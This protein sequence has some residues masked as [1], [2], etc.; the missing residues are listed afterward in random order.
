M[1]LGTRFR[2]VSLRSRLGLA[3]LAILATTVLA[4]SLLLITAWNASAVL[5]EGRQAQDR[6]RIYTQIQDAAR[7]YQAASYQAV[8]DTSPQS[9]R[10][11]VEQRVRLRNLLDAAARL[12]ARTSQ[13]I[14]IRAEIG[15]HGQLIIAH[16]HDAGRL[17]AAVDEAWNRE[18][19]RAAMQTV[20]ELTRPTM[21]FKEVL[22]S[23]IKRGDES[24]AAA[25]RRARG[26]IRNAVLAG[27]AG[28][29]CALALAAVIQFLLHAR[30]R[31]ALKRLEEGADAFRRGQLDH[32]IELKGNDEL[33]RLASTFNHMAETVADKHERLIAARKG[34]EHAV[35]ARTCELEQANAKLA[36]SDR[37][38]RAFLAD[39]SHELRTPLT[40]IR[41]ETQVAM[42]ICDNPAFEPHEAFERILEQTED[43][44]RLVDDLFLI[45]RAEAG[46][47]PLD[48]D[49]TDLRKLCECVRADF[50]ALAGES[51]TTI[52]VKGGPPLF[53]AVD[54]KRL[55]RAFAA[56]IDN[57]LRHCQPGVQ[58]E[59]DVRAAGA[60]MVVAISDN[61]PGV[62]FAK[63]NLFFERFYRGGA[64]GEGSGLGLSL[65]KALV[66]AHGGS[67]ALV[68]AR[69]GG[70]TVE[71]RLPAQA[72]QSVAA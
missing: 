43:L 14:R 60:S 7:S 45:A 6:V 54:R 62:D 3:A 28:L 69:G 31:P 72:D 63:S 29:A 24:L 32:R 16:F 15:R 44:G 67:A 27:I 30:L 38:R 10:G 26:Q 71:L 19:S 34:L 23:E 41:G 61:G 59:L 47:L 17:V 65:V 39:V 5:A 48:K 46:G 58:I 53:S 70:T 40:V 11:V 18:G 1:Q 35:A 52:A 42:R 49:E 36:E 51:G 4:T 21:E 9:Q 25:S 8:R 33:T 66:E 2:P 50:E 57:A 64:R 55:K 37:R 20:A 22:N 56:I 12:P 68:P 13:E